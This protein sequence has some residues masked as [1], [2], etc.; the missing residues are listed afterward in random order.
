MSQDPEPELFP[1]G[2]G[3]SIDTLPPVIAFLTPHPGDTVSGTVTVE[4]QAQDATQVATLTVAIG[5]VDLPDSD[6]TAGRFRTE[7]DPLSTA[8]IEEL[9]ATLAGRYTLVVV[10]HNLAQARRVSGR[11]AF[12][13]PGDDGAGRLVELADTERFFAEPETAQARDYLRGRVG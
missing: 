4:V 7:L 10:T 1:P 3:G 13:W 6:D 2:G 12:L 9:L 5:G 8:R 11:C